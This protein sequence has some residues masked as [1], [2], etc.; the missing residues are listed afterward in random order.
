MLAGG[1]GATVNMASTAGVL[2][3][4]GIGAYVGAKHGIVGLTRSAALDYGERGVR[5]NALAPG[6]I[7]NDRIAALSDEQRR[8]IADAVPV[9]RIGTPEEVAA[10]VAWLCSDQASYITGVVLPIDGGQLARI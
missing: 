10:A 7:L 1:G 5:I 6:P 9:R 4:R 2:G 3:W 8:P